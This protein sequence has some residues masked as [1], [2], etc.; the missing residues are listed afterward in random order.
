MRK[1]ALFPVLMVI[2]LL[3]GGYHMA[4]AQT[5]A[6]TIITFASSLESLTVADAEAGNLTTTLTWRTANVTAGYQVTLHS[7][8]QN[9]WIAVFDPESVP[10][11]A[12][13]ARVV[14]VRHPQNF[15][16]PTFL[17]SITDSQSRIVEQ[18]T[19]SIPYEID[20]SAEPEIET[21]TA[22]VSEIDANALVSGGAFVEMTWEISN[23][24]PTANPVFEQVFDDNTSVPIELP[25]PYLWIASSG[26]GP[27]RPVWRDGLAR[28]RLRMQVK[29]LASGEV[30]AEQEVVLPITGSITLPIPTPAP[31]ITAAA[32][33]P[34]VTPANTQIASFSATPSTV[35]PGAAITLTWTVRGTGGVMIE[36]V[37]P[38]IDAADVVVTAQ[39]PQGTATVYLPDYAAYTVQYTLW[40]ADRVSSAQAVVQVHCP[41]T[42]FF[43]EGDGCPSTEPLS[44]EAAY[45]EFEGGFMV[46]RGDTREIYA[47]IN[48]ASG[49][50]T[51]EYYL[52][53]AFDNLPE[54]N[55]ANVPPLDRFAPVSGFGRVWTNTPGLADKL[56]WALAPEEGYTT[57]LQQVAMARDPIPEFAFYLTL[58]DGRVLGSGLGRWRFVQ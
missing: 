7:Y 18:R 53:S 11:E 17:L 37:V 44:I 42:F 21:L 39:S 27:V 1:Y 33:P 14:T 55:P 41:Y 23:R 40:T 49:G 58:P 22:S 3:L 15:G 2:A 54:N 6:P 19:L 48:D 5:P 26:H 36:Q 47:F 45:Q 43:G 46:W 50:G 8:Q 34:V 30:Y 4:S 31:T 13:G 56:G 20:D 57:T 51:T 25:R 12:N 16:P 28:V 9:R 24:P 38:G 10:L 29:D 52:E 35:N 32:P